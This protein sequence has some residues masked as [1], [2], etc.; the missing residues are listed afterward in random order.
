[1]FATLGKMKDG[2]LRKQPKYKP[3]GKIIPAGVFFMP[4]YCLIFYIVYVDETTQDPAESG[5]IYHHKM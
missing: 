4:F 3:V 2:V 1:M 5:H